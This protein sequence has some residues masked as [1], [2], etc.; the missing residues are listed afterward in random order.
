MDIHQTPAGE[1]VLCFCSDPN[2][3]NGPRIWSAGCRIHGFDHSLRFQYPATSRKMHPPRL[4]QH[5]R[6]E[7]RVV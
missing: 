1:I 3:V 2:G 4:S 5:K 6:L 7:E